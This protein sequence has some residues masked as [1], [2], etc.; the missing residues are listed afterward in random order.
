MTRPDLRSITAPDVLEQVLEI[1]DS[2]EDESRRMAA[3]TVTPW[4]LDSRQEQT[5]REVIKRLNNETCHHLAT[6]DIARQIGDLIRRH[7]VHFGLPA[8]KN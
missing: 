4:S 6:A 1:I 2:F 5:M 7:F 3:E 8:K